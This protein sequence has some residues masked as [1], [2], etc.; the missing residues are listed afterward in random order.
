MTMDTQFGKVGKATAH[1]VLVED[2]PGDVYLLEKALQAR[3]IV[4]ELTRYEDGEQG[5]RAL[6]SERC[7]TPD[8]IL[9][10][11][12]LP[13][14]EGFDVLRAV[15]TRP[16]LVGVAVGILTSSDAQRD[17]HRV[18]LIGAERYI[19]KPLTLEEFIDEVGQAIEDMLPH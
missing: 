8:L 1:I 9:L 17:R 11:L 16:A 18:F 14:R 4:Y 13:R 19:H 12:N 15:R 6:S 3:H 5:I 2:N 7:P 10:D